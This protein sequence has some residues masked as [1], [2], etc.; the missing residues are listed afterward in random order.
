MLVGFSKRG[1]VHRPPPA[2]GPRMR[3]DRRTF[4]QQTLRTLITADPQLTGWIQPLRRFRHGRM[5]SGLKALAF[6]SRR[7]CSSVGARGEADERTKGPS[8]G[9]DLDERQGAVA[10]GTLEV[11]TRRTRRTRRTLGS[12]AR[13]G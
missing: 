13:L 6:L 1:Q 5:S 8:V 11:C 9:L 10:G 2:L 4:A 12:R 3:G 7:R